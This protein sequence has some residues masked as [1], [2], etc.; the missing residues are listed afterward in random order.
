MSV[1]GLGTGRRR[2]RLPL[3]ELISAGLLLV[4][5]LLFVLELVSFSLQRDRLQADITVAGITVGGLSPAEAR[6]RWEVAYAQPV[7]L[8]YRGSPILLDP[9]SVGFQPNSEVM[10]AQSLAESASESSFWLA[11]WNYLWRRPVQPINVPLDAD[12]QTTLVRQYLENIAARYDRPPGLPEPV[13]DTLTFQA[14]SA[15][16][17]F[18]IEVTLALVDRA[19]RDPFDRFVELPVAERDPA[20]SGLEALSNLI[21][22]YL[23]SQG[24]IYDGQTTVASVYIMDLTTGEE[25]N[26]NGDVAFSAASTMKLPILLST[27][28][29]LSFAP[30]EDIAWLMVNS[31]LCSNNSSS[32]FLLDT[33]GQGDTWAGLDYVTETLAQVGAS[34]TYIT[35]PFD[36]GIEGQELRSNP[37]PQTNPNPRFDTDPDPFNQTTAED[38]GTLLMLI[39]DC[40]RYDSGLRVAYPEGEYTQTECQQMLEIMSGNDL[41]RLIQGGVPAGT[42]VSHKNGW[43]NTIHADAGIVFPPNGRDYIISVFIWEAGNFFSY[44]R[45]WPLIEG[46]SRAAWNYFSPEQPLLSR[47]PDLPAN[48]QECAS[49]LPPA[50]D[51]VNLSDIDWWRQ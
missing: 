17:T 19:L 36:L 16:Y 18:D 21:I 4:A 32:N 31:L 11:F 15:G 39:Y 38:L 44:E 41:L 12:Y 28:R 40:A 34:N 22:A 5:L 43:L 30:S 6:A 47:R 33:M 3:L 25:I 29:F 14:G 48:A 42:R 26:L 51:A 45:A 9:A 23:D 24:F 10:L 27:Y 37:I 35:A 13:L 7:E 1:A 20:D 2:F 49:F 46:I 8:S 50:P